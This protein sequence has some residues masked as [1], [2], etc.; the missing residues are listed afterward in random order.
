MA[1]LPF[2]VDEMIA[3]VQAID[4]APVKGKAHVP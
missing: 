2:Q 3:A 1:H 4:A